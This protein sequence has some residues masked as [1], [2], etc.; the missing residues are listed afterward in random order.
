MISKRQAKVTS[1]VIKNM[2]SLYSTRGFK[3]EVAIMDG[4]FEVQHG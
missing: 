1:R 3:I 4:G 2:N